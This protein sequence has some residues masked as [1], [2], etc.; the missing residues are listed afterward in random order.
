M[1][2]R[3]LCC[4]L[5]LV[6]SGT[7]CVVGA[8]ATEG[9]ARGYGVAAAPSGTLSAVTTPAGSAASEAEN[10]TGPGE[11]TPSTTPT[12]TPAPVPEVTV[13]G[14]LSNAA[15]PASTAIEHTLRLGFDAPV[16]NGTTVLFPEA[17][18]R[19][20]VGVT[21]VR[22]AGD[23]SA[24]TAVSGR[25]TARRP[26]NGTAVR[27]GI[28]LTTAGGVRN[29]TVEFTA[30]HPAVT[31][32]TDYVLAVAGPVSEAVTV[33]AYRVRPIGPDSRSGLAGEFDRAGGEGF[34]YPNATVYLGERDIEFSGGLSEPLRGVGGSAAGTLLET[35]IPTGAT[36][37]TYSVDG[38]ND[39][40]SIQLQEP[41][42]TT[43]R[44]ENGDGTDVTGGTVYADSTD[45]VAV[46]AQSNF[47]TAEN[48]ELTVTNRQGLDV[49]DELINT[50]AVRAETATGRPVSPSTE[51]LGATR[52]AQRRDADGT[53]PRRTASAP[54]DVTRRPGTAAIGANDGAAGVDTDLAASG[55]PSSEIDAG[56]TFTIRYDL[57]NSG[58][59]EARSAGFNPSLP[60][61]I[62]VESVSGAGTGSPARFITSPVAAGETVGVTYT[63]RVASGAGDGS[64]DVGMTGSV[65]PDTE[66]TVSVT[67]T[68]TVDGASGVGSDVGSAGRVRWQLDLSALETSTLSVA[69]A[70]SDDLDSG[71][72]RAETELTISQ[73]S[74]E[75]SFSNDT[76]NRGQRP[77]VT[78]SNGV[79]GAEYV[80]GIEAN[81]LRN[82]LPTSA[83]DSVFRD[84][85]TTE[86]VGVVTRSAVQFTD[87]ER[88]EG[89]PIG[90]YARVRVDPDD[91]RGQTRLETT[92]L[93]ET[94]TV[95]LSERNTSAVDLFE[96]VR[97]ADT[98]QL[99][100]GDPVITLSGPDSY[101]VGEETTLRGRAD[102]GIDG[103]VLYARS[104]GTSE[105]ELVD[106]DGSTDGRVSGLSVSGPFGKDVELSSGDAPGNT[107]LSFPGTY[108]VAALPEADLAEGRS[109][110][111]ETLAPATVL[112][113]THSLHTVRI[114]RPSVSV[115]QPG[116]DGR[117]A[118]SAGTVEVDGSVSGRESALLVAIGERGALRTETVGESNFTD[119][120]MSM[121]GFPEGEVT[122]HAVSSGRDGRIGD[123]SIREVRIATAD[124]PLSELRSHL[125]SVA[126]TVR[127][128]DQIRAVLRNET[129]RDT[130]SDDPVAVERFR[131]VPAN[132]EIATP[133][134]N[135]TVGSG[136]TL[137]IA[138]RTTVPPR[139]APIDV[140]VARGIGTDRRRRIQ[141]DSDGSWEVSFPTGDLEPGVY[142]ITARVDG[143]VD[144]RVVLIGNATSR[145]ARQEVRASGSAGSPAEDPDPSVAATPVPSSTDGRE[146]PAGSDTGSATRDGAI[147]STGVTPAAASGDSSPSSTG[148]SPLAGSG[149]LGLVA[150]AACLAG[151]L[152]VLYRR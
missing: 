123:G 135:A 150:L 102:G 136:T 146:S 111:P 41:E 65:G 114:R 110:L 124:S 1:D 122:V 76:P 128:G 54:P 33:A 24:G 20:D 141:P 118:A 140:S 10:T 58:D 5:L 43:L 70:G 117:L 56:D 126:E 90:V 3:I 84:V 125:Q 130:A 132:V 152:L 96:G 72:A 15:P 149:P 138:G 40:A 88:I 7:I 53:D 23:A 78:V 115:A 107:L 32:E 13:D 112:D 14:S 148:R 98:G 95:E 127:N 97:S 103:M 25:L 30:R 129:D 63:F 79:Y 104:N 16:A 2:R 39:T 19:S 38:A 131:I 143:V 121:A 71:R 120:E 86:E 31:N 59:R 105:F 57:T 26:V 61:A 45:T 49:T 151:A 52:S 28:E 108:R 89:E 144:R 36:T 119:V 9:A 22:A 37:G 81:D 87:G 109:T 35:P 142:R 21:S 50:S 29:V 133:E 145:T 80:V 74:P 18:S 64:Y 55:V 44:L 68:V 85:G 94:V 69:V 67:S 147:P 27:P 101:V 60:D 46:V 48:L 92:T 139:V 75:L 91:G 4:C 42:I 11:T 47:E 99:R 51:P 6:A 73:Q 34:V 93:G 83:Y 82:D 137:R 106:L 17:Y 62:S 116:L 77:T 12:P 8:A 134:Q 100:I 66:D 113:A